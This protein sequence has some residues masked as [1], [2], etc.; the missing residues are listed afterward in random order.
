MSRPV[1][2][3][4]FSLTATLLVLAAAE[5]AW[6]ALVPVSP[7]EQASRDLTKT[8]LA[9][10]EPCA[11]ADARQGN[12]GR[13]RQPGVARV[14]F[15]GE[16]TA[17]MLGDAARELLARDPELPFE[18]LNCAA[19]G[20][21]LEHVE[22]RADE[23]L[24]YAPDAVVVAF[25]HNLMTRGFSTDE[26]RLRLQSLLGRSRLISGL[27]N[28]SGMSPRVLPY[29]A[30]ARLETLAAWLE[31]FGAAARTKGVTV[32]VT[33]MASNAW[34]PP[35]VLRE[36]LSDPAFLA[37]AFD[38]A[39]GHDESA[40]EA[41]TMLAAESPE[42]YWSFIS[43]TWEARD[44]EA[45]RAREDLQKAIDETQL[46][47]D[48]ASS[49]VNERIRTIAR[50]QRL[51]LRDTDAEMRALS[52]GIVG[53]NLMR[54]S[55]HPHP[56][57]LREEA[58][59]LLLL[60]A[61]QSTPAGARDALAHRV[62]NVAALPSENSNERDL[63]AW[64]LGGLSGIHAGL[65]GHPR[66]RCARAI[67]YF[68]EHWLRSEPARASSAFTAFADGPEFAT[69][70]ARSKITQLV[71]I[72]EGYSWAGDMEGAG[73]M[74]ERARN[75]IVGS[76]AADADLRYAIA[77]AWSQLG[78]FELS[79]SESAPAVKSFA[80]ALE[81]T[82]DHAEAAYFLAKLSRQH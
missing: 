1:R 79:R 30:R 53:W 3:L 77:D 81:A 47:T 43:G 9:F 40:R 38:R 25:G 15:V 17:L 32:I 71:S 21:A 63:V 70:D 19:A 12:F 46:D 48:R 69:M 64:M 80:R 34:F 59:E 24:R 20:C 58:G 39:R 6:R 23:V 49:A 62:R 78:R 67:S 37:A 33:T 7:G 22:R 8:S 65:G 2:R 18:I 36:T 57:Y 61:E 45:E 54:D 28:R 29:D 26:W 42:A 74:N 14:A 31:H 13:R 75:V 60:A 82:E 73:R 27:A 50:E 55:C 4:A 10:L 76:E 16:S 56:A 35:A 52:G 44:G 41:L 11:S 66:D 5:V 68:V 72:A 51:V